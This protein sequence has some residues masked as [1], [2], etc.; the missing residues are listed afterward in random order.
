[1]G[2]KITAF[3]IKNPD[4]IKRGNIVIFRDDPIFV[5][6][7]VAG[8]PGEIIEIKNG[9]IYINGVLKNDIKGIQKDRSN[10]GPFAIPERSLF[11]LGDNMK[12]SRDSRKEGPIPFEKIQ[13]KAL[14]VYW[15]FTHIKFLI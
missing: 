4:N 10:Y 12:V 8:L 13:Y 1:M 3:R 7:R 9:D 14:A 11:L 15:P 6:K 2:D 5:I